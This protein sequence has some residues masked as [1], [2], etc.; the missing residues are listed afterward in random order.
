MAAAARSEKKEPEEK[1]RDAKKREEKT[2]VEADAAEAPAKAGSAV[3]RWLLIGAVALVVMSGSIGTALYLL[4]PTD[5]E[6]EP[7]PAKAAPQLKPAIYQD[8][9]PSF[10]VHFMDGQ[11][12]RYLQV[13]LAVMSRDPAVMDAIKVHAPL[14]RG[15][16]IDA[17]GREPYVALATEE[18]KQRMREEIRALIENIVSREAH[19]S[20]VEAVLL[21]NFVVQ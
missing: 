19:V 1:T 11:K 9:K 3:G 6:A 20:G 12:P 2:A 4:A 15:Q 7:A 18:G 17:I 13:E 14:I 8:L 10:I 21:T 5:G 16:I